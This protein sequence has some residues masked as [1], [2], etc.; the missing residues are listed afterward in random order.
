VPCADVYFRIPNFAAGYVNLDN[1]RR[2]IL[3]APY[4]VPED[5]KADAEDDDHQ[6][7]S[8]ER[9]SKPPSLGH[10]NLLPEHVSSWQRFPY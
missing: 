10:T 5:A 6:G 2:L 9:E 7:Q 8:L 3:N 4:S 1:N